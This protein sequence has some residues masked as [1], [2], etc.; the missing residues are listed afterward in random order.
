M[1]RLEGRIAIITGAA[2]GIGF[3]IAS[4]F[5]AEGATLLLADIQGEAVQA[6]ATRL[7]D[8][9]GVDARA[10][11]VDV[12]VK[13]DVV[14]M[15]GAA[16]DE[17][18]R[19]D[20]LVNNAWGGGSLS[21]FEHKTDEGLDAAFRVG[22]YGPV[23]AMR[24]ALPAMRAAG[25]G[26]VINLCSLNGVN[27][28]MGTTEYNSAKEALRA[29]SRTAAREWAGYGICVNVICPGAKTAASRRVFAENPEL[30]AAADASNP[31]GRLGDPEQDIAPVAVFLASDDCRYLTG[32]TLFVDGGSHINGAPWAPVLP[33]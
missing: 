24:T 14:A 4:R 15:V 7:G 26:R 21:R 13:D 5:A 19:L 1:G 3:G 30:E 27:A 25:Y 18:G 29:A 28:H 8:E 31:M 16:L 32:N 10:R 23:W 11:T 6:V 12:G 2:D 17:W 9:H 22:Y 33:E 20:I